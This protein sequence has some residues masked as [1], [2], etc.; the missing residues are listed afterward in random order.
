LVPRFQLQA[1]Y[2]DSSSYIIPNGS[3]DFKQG[4][5]WPDGVATVSGLLTLSSSIVGNGLTELL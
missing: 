5:L 3:A 2:V 1:R 4:I